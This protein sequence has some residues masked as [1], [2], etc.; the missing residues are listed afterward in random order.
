MIRQRRSPARHKAQKARRGNHGSDTQRPREAVFSR[1]LN[2][3]P[4]G[5]PPPCAPG[6]IQRQSS[7]ETP[8]FTGRLAA[9]QA[10]M[11]TSSTCTCAGPR[12]AAKIFGWPGWQRFALTHTDYAGAVRPRASS[13]PTEIQIGGAVQQ[14]ETIQ[15]GA[16]C[17]RDGVCGHGATRRSFWAR[18]PRS[19]A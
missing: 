19:A 18:L 15:C 14:T 10:R 17:I 2:H 12:A 4:G 9:S 16:P 13:P 7:L 6:A 1:V 8:R 5:P 3:R 11:P